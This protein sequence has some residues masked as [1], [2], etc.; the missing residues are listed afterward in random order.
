[1]EDEND[2]PTHLKKKQQKDNAMKFIET[3]HKN[4]NLEI[5]DLEFDDDSL[6]KKNSAKFD[7]G[8]TIGLLM[9]NLIVI[10]IL[11]LKLFKFLD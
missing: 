10:L 5:N 7:E 11:R 2:E 6:L 3:N 1:M 8:G 4:I 9:N